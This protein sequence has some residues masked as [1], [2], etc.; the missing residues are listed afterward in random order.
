M[1]VTTILFNFLNWVIFVYL[2]F[3]I[4]KIEENWKVGRSTRYEWASKER[5][6]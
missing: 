1:Q 5:W 6:C 4:V 2:T 3:F